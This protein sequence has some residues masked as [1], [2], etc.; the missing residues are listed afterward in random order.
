M[1]EFQNI[2]L[3]LL[4]DIFQIISKIKNTVSWTYN[5][6]DLNGEEITG[7][8]YEK[9]LRKAN[10]KEFRIEKVLKRKSDKLYVKW[11]GYDNRFNI[12]IDK[13]D[14]LIHVLVTV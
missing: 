2:K 3:Y 5:I 13:K 14:I 9:E 10:Q 7:I 1:L 8:F 4:K 6:S 12:C 11:N